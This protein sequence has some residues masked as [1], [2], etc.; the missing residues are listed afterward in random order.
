M[1]VIIKTNRDGRTRH[2]SVDTA[3]T[4]CFTYT[5]VH[6]QSFKNFVIHSKS[7]ITARS[8]SN[9][10]TFSCLYAEEDG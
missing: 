4:L 5:L 7:F 10:L 8:R 1:F 2:I 9:T 6:L 3:T